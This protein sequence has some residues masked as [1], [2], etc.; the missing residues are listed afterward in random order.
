M[1][2]FAIIAAACVGPQAAL[3]NAGGEAAQTAVSLY[4]ELVACVAE[5]SF[6]QFGI[7][8]S[9]PCGDWASRTDAARANDREMMSAGF[10]C[11]A[12]DV[13]IAGNSAVSGDVQHFAFVGS[14]VDDCREQL[15][16]TN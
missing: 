11:L 9:G 15:A 5:P 2:H 13:R 6:G 14:V 3:A 7:A 8:P 1:R 16:G 10:F 4:D 12:G